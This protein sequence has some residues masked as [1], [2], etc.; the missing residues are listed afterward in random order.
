MNQLIEE[1]CKGALRSYKTF[2]ASGHVRLHTVQDFV[3]WHFNDSRVL[4][5]STYKHQ[6]RNIEVETDQ[7]TI[8]FRNRRHYI[9]IAQPALQYE[10]LSLNHTGMVLEDSTRSQK[11]FFARL[12]AWESLVSNS[13][14]VL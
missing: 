6:Q 8:E 2:F 1:Q 14:P 13:L 9:Q 4:T 12:P 3:E 11:Q 5:I 10:I 7:W